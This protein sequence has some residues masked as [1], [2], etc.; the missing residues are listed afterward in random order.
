MTQSLNAKSYE[1]NW[2][3][4]QHF[5]S[6][7]NCP[8]LQDWRGGQRRAIPPFNLHM[9]LFCIAYA[10][11]PLAMI[12]AVSLRRSIEKWRKAGGDSDSDLPQFASGY[13]SVFMF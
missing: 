10:I 8:L 3:M 12:L 9:T 5:T 13:I 7:A 6:L 11:L 1:I 2:R 4:M